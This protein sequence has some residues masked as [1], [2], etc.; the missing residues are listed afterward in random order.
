MRVPFIKAARCKRPFLPPFGGLAGGKLI[1]L[2]CAAQQME[3]EGAENDLAAVLSD[4]TFQPERVAEV[5][6]TLRRL[7]WS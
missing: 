4:R 3:E 2:W 7:Q 1:A 6:S 5:S